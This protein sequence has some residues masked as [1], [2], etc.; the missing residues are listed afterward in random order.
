MLLF[1]KEN[2]PFD[3]TV[4]C[5]SERDTFSKT[6]KLTSYV[7]SNGIEL[8]CRSEENHLKAKLDLR[9]DGDGTHCTTFEFAFRHELPSILQKCLVIFL[10]H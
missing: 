9:P 7:E 10:L 2:C 8:Q 6:Y 5:D 3:R 4:K 1:A